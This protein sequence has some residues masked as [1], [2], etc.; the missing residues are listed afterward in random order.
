VSTLDFEEVAERHTGVPMAWFFREW[1]DGTA[2]PS[3]ILSSHAEPAEAGHYILRVR[4]RQEDVPKDFIM[5]VPLQVDLA[6]ERQVLVRGNVTGRVTEGTL[7]VPAEPTRL[8]LNPRIAARGGED[9]ELALRTPR[10]RRGAG[11]ACPR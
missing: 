10:D 9:G 1:V 2:I 11:P 6:D 4:V 3:Y 7:K 5:P 8:E